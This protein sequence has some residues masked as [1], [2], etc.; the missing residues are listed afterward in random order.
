MPA[1][2]EPHSSLVSYKP[3]TMPPRAIAAPI[4]GAAVTIA[5]IASLAEDAGESDEEPEEEEE[6]ESAV[7]LL[8]DA[9]LLPVDWLELPPVADFRGICVPAVQLV[10][11]LEPR[12][13]CR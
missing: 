2:S 11:A 8:E 9:S 3:T 6:E 12:L 4:S 1:S 5:R 13:I 10:G 7:A